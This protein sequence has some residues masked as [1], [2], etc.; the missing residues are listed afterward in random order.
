MSSPR[1][2]V[3]AEL[4]ISSGF[5]AFGVSVAAVGST[6]PMGTIRSIGPGFFPVWLGSLVAILSAILVVGLV[7]KPASTPQREKP[8]LPALPWRALLAIAA[9]LWVWTMLA[10]RFGL[11]LAT[12]GLGLVA[13]FAEPRSGLWP[14]LAMAAVLAIGA[15]IV[16]GLMLD[17]RLPIL[18]R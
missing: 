13:T 7:L 6:Y 8:S 10:E 4:I 15:S 5:V 2:L 3:R 16:F 17:V 14:S 9:S 12:F 11:A 18:I 1:R